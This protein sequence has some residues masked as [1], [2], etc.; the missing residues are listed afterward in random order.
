MTNCDVTDVASQDNTHKPGRGSI[1]YEAGPRGCTTE[2][3][4]CPF[5]AAFPS[6]Q[7]M[8]YTRMTS[9]A[10]TLSRLIVLAMLAASCG[11]TAP[12]WQGD[13]PIRWQNIVPS[14]DGGPGFTSLTE[15][16]TRVTFVNDPSEE[17]TTLNQHLANGAGVALGDLNG[18][19][20]V[21]IFLANTR[22]ENALYLNRGGLRFEEV[23]ATAGVHLTDRYPTGVALADG[24]GDGDLDLFISSM[25]APLTYLENDGL[26]HFTNQSNEAG[27]SLS[28]AG[29]TM[30]LA[31]IDG[32]G[33]LD[34]YAAN[35]RLDRAADAFSPEDRR[36]TPVLEERDGEWV[37]NEMYREYYQVVLG[38]EGVM[39]WEFGEED[40]LY[41]N[42]GSG[43]FTRI[44]VQ[45]DRFREADGTPLDL[46]PQDWGL[47]ARFRDLNQDG[48]PDLYVANDFESPDHIWMNDGSGTFQRM[49]GPALR[50]TSHASMSVAFAD[51]DADG[52]TDIFVADMLPLST[53]HRKTQVSTLTERRA[54]P[55]VVSATMQVN[56]NTL[57]LSTPG[58]GYTEVGQQ[59]GVAASG[60]TWGTEFVDVDLDGYQDLLAANGHRWD[61]LDA[62]TGE[63]LRQTPAT[64]GADW[65]EVIN[66]FPQ[67][68]TSNVAFRNLGDGNFELMP[69]GWGLDVGPDIS[70]G[71][72]TGDLD[73]DGD[74][75]VVVNRLGDP[76][77]VLRNDAGAARL[78]VR[79]IGSRPNTAAVGASITVT[80]GPVV[81]KRE[82]GAGGLYLSH[83][84]GAQS[85]AVGDTESLTI[86]VRW[87]DG[88][89]SVEADA[90]PNRIYEI[91]QTGAAPRPRVATDTDASPA[92]FERIAGGL[93]PQHKDAPFDPR[94]DQILLPRTLSRLGPGVTWTDADSDGDADLLVGGG[95]GGT[96]TSWENT[97]GRFGA[98]RPSTPLTLDVT[99]ILPEPEPAAAIVGVANYEA[100]DPEAA[101]AAAPALT[102]S[103][104][105][106][107]P[108]GLR[109]TLTSNGASTGPLASADVDGDGDLDVFM[110]G[111]VYQG[112]YPLAPMSR[113]FIR[114][115]AGALVYDSV[116]SAPLSQTGLVS[117]AT[118][119]DIDGDA[120]PDLVLAMDWGPPRLFVNQDGRFFDRTREWGLSEYSS[121]W[122]GVTA[123][124]LDSDGR[125]DLVL[126]SWGR[127]IGL[128]PEPGR[129]LMAY[130]GD[131][132]R[133]GT[134]DVL[135]AMQD[136]RIGGVAPLSNLLRLSTGLP[137][138][139]RQTTP[140]FGAYADATLDQI[141]GP[142]SETARMHTVSTLG[143]MA[144]LS[145]GD[146]FEALRLPAKSQ[147]APA[148][149]VSVSDFDGDGSED[150]ILAQNFFPNATGAERRDAGYGML[151]LGDGGGT[152]RA[153]SPLESGIAL[154]G[155]QRGLAVADFDGDARLDVA[156]GQNSGSTQLLHNVGATPGLRV[157]LV[158]PPSNR[159][160]VGAA[161]RIVYSNRMGPAREV[162]MGSGFWSVDDPVQVMGLQSGAEAI[163]VRWPNGSIQR[164]EIEDGTLEVTVRQQN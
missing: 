17:M 114:N 151:L 94:R 145:R 163:E 95:A 16:Q 159:H 93:S 144:F 86:E 118:F 73:G 42:D 69:N 148:H 105:G 30:S 57:L 75:D 45:G 157:R 13:G 66:L 161:I 38:P 59:A 138:V 58:A 154:T 23:G 152:L 130:W 52:G 5:G 28:R 2:P 126:T 91:S 158:G 67:L 139:R 136:D 27:F 110:G 149:G 87:P 50:K 141:L 116:A 77:L 133:S 123:G 62:D 7:H 104:N 22:G 121:W 53:R 108:G 24:D 14:G 39:S 68:R 162:R 35:Y 146:R 48:A 129:P 153:T 54:M 134:L 137:F 127:N 150:I 124:D 76:A 31:D 96:I 140:T 74:L 15:R 8:T 70:H 72:A 9:R 117:A 142:A 125:M 132:D 155:D 1:E 71:L 143:H 25:G 3:T 33:D 46:E 99:T 34:L 147:E 6:I 40:D 83:A 100:P 64:A 119:T 65:H 63:R 60:W 107:R 37:V 164:V 32:D 29:S 36:D 82:V 102:M 106:M 89:Y 156:I 122:N 113:L 85:F 92:L 128:R 11:E 103:L 81:Q 101:R 4:Q 55:G 79:L 97:G 51:V 21:D 131:F 44:P 18:D 10:G 47:S 19:G 20:D 135:L 43:R 120:D 26:G 115:A 109:P 56:R 84:D 12:E 112:A 88:T 49:G 80:G 61:P 111:R 41:L 98:G 160:G 78:A 90:L